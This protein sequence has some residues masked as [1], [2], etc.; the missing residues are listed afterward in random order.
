MPGYYSLSYFN[1]IKLKNSVYRYFF[2]K[3]THPTCAEK[4]YKDKKNSLAK[5][6]KDTRYSDDALSIHGICYHKTS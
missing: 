5:L 4:Y 3:A 6:G 1:K 2:F